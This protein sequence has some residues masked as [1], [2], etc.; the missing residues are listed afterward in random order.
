M[1]VTSAKNAEFKRLANIKISFQS[2]IVLDIF[3]ILFCRE[4]KVTRQE[5]ITNCSGAARLNEMTSPYSSAMD[6]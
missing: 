4:R 3:K 2:D 1:I 5:R 6:A